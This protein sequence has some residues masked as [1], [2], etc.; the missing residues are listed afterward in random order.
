MLWLHPRGRAGRRSLAVAALLISPLLLLLVVWPAAPGAREGVQPSASRVSRGERA[1][2]SHWQL[3]AQWTLGRWSSGDELQAVQ[4]QLSEAPLSLQQPRAQAALTQLHWADVND[5]ECPDLLL[6]ARSS[7]ASQQPEPAQLLLLLASCDGSASGERAAPT[8]AAFR[9]VSQAQLGLGLD[10]QA[11]PSA[12]TVAGGAPDVP[13]L[14]ELLDLD[15]DYDLD[16]CQSTLAPVAD[17]AGGCVWTTRCAIN[18]L[19][20]AQPPDAAQAS[21]PT[22]PLFIPL[23]AV[24][25]SAARTLCSTAS[26]PAQAAMIAMDSDS[27]GTV[28]LLQPPSA[29]SSRSQPFSFSSVSLAQGVNDTL[30][31]NTA[32]ALSAGR[33]L[34]PSAPAQNSGIDTA[35]DQLVSGKQRGAESA[36]SASSASVSPSACSLLLLADLDA[37]LV[38]ELLCFGRSF[39][40][41]LRVFQLS[42]VGAR[43]ALLERADL[44]PQ[45]Q[46]ASGLTH[47]SESLVTDA[48]LGDFNNDGLPD[49]VLGTANAGVQLALSV[50]SLRL[51]V[52]PQLQYE[53]KQLG[54][55][56]PR[57]LAVR[58]V[59][60]F[61][62]DND[63]DL[64]ILAVQHQPDPLVQLLHNDGHGRRFDA[65]RLTAE[66]AQNGLAGAAVR[67]VCSVADFDS[68]GWLDVA[69]G[70]SLGVVSLYRNTPAL[71]AGNHWLEVS[72]Y[73]TGPANALGYGAMVIVSLDAGRRRM[74]RI[75]HHRGAT[76]AGS[77]SGVPASQ[78]WHRLHFGLGV[79]TMVDSVSVLWPTSLVDADSL[80]QYRDVAADQHLRVLY[81]TLAPQVPAVARV[82]QRLAGWSA[83][84]GGCSRPGQRR[85]RPSL[86]ILGQAK[87]G[88]T[89]LALTLA[90]H[91]HVLLAA[92]KE[93]HYFLYVH[94]L[95]SLDWYAQHFPCGDPQLDVTFD[96][97]TTYLSGSGVAERLLAAFPQA[98]LLVLLRDPVARAL[99]HF[100]MRRRQWGGEAAD[101]EERALQ[102]AFHTD[103]SRHIAQF[104]RCVSWQLSRRRNDTTAAAAMQSSLHAAYD[105][106]AKAGDWVLTSGLYSVL[107]RRWLS[108]LGE[109]VSASLHVFA[110]EQLHSQPQSVLQAVF[111]LLGLQRLHVSLMTENVAPDGRELR[112]LNSTERLL[113]SFYQ[114]FNQ[115]LHG[116]VA[117]HQGFVPSWMQR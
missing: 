38:L 19:P 4:L 81:S 33:H 73:G 109:R 2:P 22:A 90:Q 45:L 57:H 96:A 39:P 41:D 68:D 76:V 48:C 31:T 5:D 17:A 82:S 28:E 102:Q 117:F 55:A 89:S 52:G 80:V 58:A 100:R 97:S 32:A 53:L 98:K 106:C 7:P 13:S 43:T 66:P 65:V 75:A 62:A 8:A 95:L 42:R 93:L 46:L 79:H 72:L 105:A 115:Q 11:P 16:L 84:D 107:L 37:D 30:P 34:A 14:L 51:P 113:R 10:G 18:Q 24:E 85:L 64:D 114:P 54:S 86:F 9:T 94:R 60:C 44:A 91:P 49:Y 25:H 21:P 74:C 61:D 12:A 99:S 88:T 23:P 20:H 63:G 112:M 111:D 6:A 116:L 40:A 83:V 92:R 101:V 15:G 59:S 87:C 47:A 71:P 1:D 110:S 3:V 70:W 36:S 69:V 67:A 27:D 103:I 29:P 56:E 77:S 50:R 108:A 35:A 78:P 26:M 104:Q